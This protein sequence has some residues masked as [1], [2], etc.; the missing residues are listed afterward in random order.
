VLASTLTFGSISVSGATI[1]NPTTLTSSRAIAA[2]QRDRHDQ[3]DR[4]LDRRPAAQS[5]MG[6]RLWTSANA[7]ER[8][9][10]GG[11]NDYTN[12]ATRH[13]RP[14]AADGRQPPS[15]DL[16]DRRDGH[17]RHP[18]T[19][20]EASRRRSR[21]RT[22]CP[23]LDFVSV[24]VQTAVG[25]AFANAFAVYRACADDEQ[26]REQLRSRS[27]TRRRRTT[28]TGRT[29]VPRPRLRACRQCRRQQ[30]AP[31]TNTATLAWP[32]ARSAR[33]RWSIRLRT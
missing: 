5:A 16:L 26:R 23:G 10:G 13:V 14:R 24:A 6:R 31:L 18:V 22:I 4:R 27:A 28:T 8:N 25:G 30:N 19:L 17:L 3:R 12:N 9:G 2:A 32:T 29:T 7:D 33:A 20:P 11:V 21:S 15:D 1:T